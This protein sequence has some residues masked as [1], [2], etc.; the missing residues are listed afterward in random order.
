MIVC[1]FYSTLPISQSYADGN[2]VYTLVGMDTP[3]CLIYSDVWSSY[4]CMMTAILVR[5]LFVQSEC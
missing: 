2:A 5:E 4:E 3:F 1:I